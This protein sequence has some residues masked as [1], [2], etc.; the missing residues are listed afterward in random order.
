MFQAR[1]RLSFLDAGVGGAAGGVPYEHAVCAGRR[2]MRPGER[3]DDAGKRRDLRRAAGL[4]AA[5]RTAQSGRALMAPERAG[6]MIVAM[7]MTRVVIKGLESATDTGH[8]EKALEAVPHV[9]SVEID[10]STRF[11][12]VEHDGAR[13]ELL[14]AAVHALGYGAAAE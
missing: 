7:T 12:M 5:H 1:E 3:R 10:P 11:A 9:A 6:T 13:P 2:A 8:L 4:K 14:V